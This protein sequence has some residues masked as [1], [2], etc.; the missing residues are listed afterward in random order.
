MIYDFPVIHN[1]LTHMANPFYIDSAHI[2]LFACFHIDIPYTAIGLTHKFYPSCMLRYRLNRMNHV[3]K[4]PWSLDM[5]YCYDHQFNMPVPHRKPP[6]IVAG[7]DTR[8]HVL[9]QYYCVVERAVNSYVYRGNMTIWT[10]LEV[11]FVSLPGVCHCF[12]LSFQPIGW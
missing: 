3:T 9:K 11:L 2:L 6:A 5:P 12:Y 4:G 8:K 1:P 10:F 7:F